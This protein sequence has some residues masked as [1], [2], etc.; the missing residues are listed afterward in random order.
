MVALYRF[1]IHLLDLDFGR[2]F[3]NLRKVIGHLYAQPRFGPAPEGLVKPDGH[4]RG[5]APS[6]VDEVIKGL[7]GYAED[8]CTLRNG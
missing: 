1:D 2:Y 8:F 3:L 4:F 5:N 6:A 7:P